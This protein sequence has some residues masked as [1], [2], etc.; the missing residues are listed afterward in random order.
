MSDVM[1]VDA[2]AL[3][4][5][6]PAFDTLAS[7]V[8]GVLSRLTSALQAEGRCWGGDEVGQS[9]E[10]DYLDGVGNTCAGMATLRDAV[11]RVGQSVLTAADSVDAADGRARSRL[12]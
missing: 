7:T 5:A 6:E 8:D 1:R 2:D 11:A 9:F 3:R 4:G 12:T 10:H